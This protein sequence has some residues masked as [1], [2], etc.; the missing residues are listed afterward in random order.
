MPCSATAEDLA[1]STAR[2]AIAEAAAA[3]K[4]HRAYTGIGSF[5]IK[6]RPQTDTY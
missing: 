6:M 4:L 2:V 3:A 5:G 1:L